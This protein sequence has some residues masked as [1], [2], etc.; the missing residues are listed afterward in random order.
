MRFQL[1]NL[2]G[3]VLVCVDILPY[4]TTHQIRLRSVC[5]PTNSIF[6]R[7]FWVCR[8]VSQHQRHG[9]IRN[10][11]ALDLY[12]KENISNSVFNGGCGKKEFSKES[13]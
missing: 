8:Y 7:L 2:L 6:G 12:A 9:K 1:G 13:T 5:I 11:E 10:N 4:F 3:G